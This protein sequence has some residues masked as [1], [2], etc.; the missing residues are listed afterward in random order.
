MQVDVRMY[1]DIFNKRTYRYYPRTGVATNDYG[2]G[3]DE[4]PI[5][6]VL[7]F[8][9]DPPASSGR[10]CSRVT[11]LRGP[12]LA[13]QSLVNLHV[14]AV[15]GM[16][17]PPL[18]LE[19]NAPKPSDANL[20]FDVIPATTVL[21]NVGQQRPPVVMMASEAREFAHAKWPCQV[22]GPR[23]HHQ[24]MAVAVV[25]NERRRAY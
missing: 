24:M 21:D 11:K 14:D 1:T 5:E 9:M 10:L 13:Y 17:N 19:H 16:T 22:A 23:C 18:V 12:L 25:R 15:A 6:G 20:T 2:D 7:T 3:I 8:E 4:R